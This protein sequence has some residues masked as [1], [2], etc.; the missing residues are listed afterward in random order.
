MSAPIEFFLVFVLI[1]VLAVVGECVSQLTYRRKSMATVRENFRSI[2]V[3]VLI[4]VTITM[5][6]FLVWVRMGWQP[7]GSVE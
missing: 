4:L 6:A 2:L 7:H 5:V 3:K 1:Y